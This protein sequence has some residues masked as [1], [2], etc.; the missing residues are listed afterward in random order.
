MGDISLHR[1]LCP[2]ASKMV[3]SLRASTA[4][5]M[6]SL[7]VCPTSGLYLVLLMVLVMHCYSDEIQMQ[8]VI[9]SWEPDFFASCSSGRTSVIAGGVASAHR[10]SSK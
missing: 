8:G 4:F 9:L 2:G 7:D 3:N 1:P 5:S 10:L 6:V